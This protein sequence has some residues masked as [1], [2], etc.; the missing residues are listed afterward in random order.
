MVELPELERRS[1]QEPDDGVDAGGAEDVPV[2][3]LPPYV[4]DP[5]DEDPPDV[6]DPP[7]EEPPVEELPA[8]NEAIG[9]PGNVYWAPGLYTLGS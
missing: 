4:E 6:E 2:E 7:V 8:M 3:E 5:P 1:L 9:G